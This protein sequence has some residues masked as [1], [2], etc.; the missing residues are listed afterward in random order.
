MVRIEKNLNEII[1]G[2]SCKNVDNFVTVNIS[3]VMVKIVFITVTEL[4]E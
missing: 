4:G 2:S 3:L 1:L